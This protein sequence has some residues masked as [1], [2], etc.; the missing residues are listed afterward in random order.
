MAYCD[1]L[2]AADQILG[3]TLDAGRGGD[4]ALLYGD[5]AI[6][7]AQLNE[8]VNRFGNALKP[9][10]GKDDRVLL[11]LK[12]S[13][14]LVA[15][16]LGV[17]R[18]GAVTVALSTRST[19]SDL[20]FAIKDSAC[21][22]IL[23][24]DEFLPV[25]EQAILKLGREPELTAIRGQAPAGRISFEALLKGAGTELPSAKVTQDDMAFW[26]YTSGTTGTPK[27]AIHCHGDVVVADYY[28]KE[29]G[30][31]PGERV[32]SSSKLFFAFALGHVLIGGLRSG[33]TA[34]LCDLWPDSQVI[35]SMVERYRPTI[36]LSVPTFY[37][38]LIRDGHSTAP[39]FKGVHSYLSAGE[40]L[41]ESLYAAWKADT[42][43]GIAEGIGATETAFMVIS[44]T[45]AC[46]KA[47]AT[48]KPMPFAQVKLLDE[49]ERPITQPNHPGILWAK[50]GSLCRGYW[51]QPDKTA[52]A[53][54]EGWF[55]TGDMFQFDEEGWWS[56]LGR[57]DDLLKI[58]GQW[59]SPLEIEECALKVP[60]I[61]EAAA[62]GV[63]NSEGLVRL[64]LFLVAEQ[65]GSEVLEEAVRQAILSALSPYKCPRAFIFVDHVPRTATGKIQRFLLRKLGDEMQAES[66]LVEG[67]RRV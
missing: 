61:L 26:L 63:K 30:F 48:G 28:M 23:L 18:I 7:F 27:A 54:K 43:V 22:A 65:G 6:S 66:G 38:N 2:N 35:A 45:P 14:D 31:G 58:S 40:A 8:R 29:F 41:P 52:L 33:T 25:Y 46:H 17:M 20:A 15:A 47:G 64:A 62:V 13:P 10:L 67:S 36:M 44:G 57:A 32:F 12:D 4:I 11:L 56:H 9:R 50:M 24:D 53:F 51:N 16:Y 5:E 19:A 42:G 34:I 3:P 60:G 37:R 1:S 21:R 39:G 55:R 59:V 49:A